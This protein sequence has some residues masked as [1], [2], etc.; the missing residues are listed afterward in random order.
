[1]PVPG[2]EDAFMDF[3]EKA[4]AEVTR[5]SRATGLSIAKSHLTAITQEEAN[6]MAYKDMKTSLYLIGTLGFY[7]VV[8]VGSIVITSV[9]IIF[10]F[11]AAFA[12]S[13]ISFVFPGLFYI[14]GAKRFGKS[15]KYYMCMAYAFLCLGAFNCILGTTSTILNILAG[16][17]S[18]E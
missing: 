1:M 2:A 6:R 13:A 10:D 17:H 16:G 4:P 12:V 8:I 9:T 5:Q 15:T 11:A 18:G 7:A 3:D 14:K